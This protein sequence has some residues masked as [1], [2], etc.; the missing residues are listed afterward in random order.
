[1][2][3]NQIFGN[4]KPEAQYFWGLEELPCLGQMHFVPAEHG[5]VGLFLLCFLTGVCSS[6]SEGSTWWDMNLTSPPLGTP[7]SSNFQ[8]SKVSDSIRKLLMLT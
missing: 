5:G 1:M 7:K 3:K 4:E 8:I 6:E 2:G